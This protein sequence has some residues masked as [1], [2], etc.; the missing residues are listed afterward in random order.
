MDDMAAL[1]DLYDHLCDKS[2]ISVLNDGDGELGIV[3]AC[4]VFDTMVE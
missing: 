2:S 1:R 4:R 3:G